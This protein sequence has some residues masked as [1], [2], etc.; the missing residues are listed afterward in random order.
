MIGT[1]RVVGSAAATT[2]GSGGFA[3]NGLGG[4]DGGGVKSE[5]VMSVYDTLALM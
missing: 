2:N 4:G 5:E 1:G 3:V